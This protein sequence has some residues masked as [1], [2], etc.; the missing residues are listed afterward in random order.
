MLIDIK[1]IVRYISRL[2]I[3]LGFPPSLYILR[4]EVTLTWMLIKLDSYFLV[5]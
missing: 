4:T 5:L 3:I 1:C 2:Q